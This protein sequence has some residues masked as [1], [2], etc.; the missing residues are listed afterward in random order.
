MPYTKEQQKEYMKKWRENNKK[1]IKEYKV[2]NKNRDNLKNKELRCKNKEKINEYN[3]QYRKDNPE[4]FKKVY[5]KQHY[6]MLV[7]C[8]IEVLY[9]N[10]LAETH[11]DFCCMPFTEQ[12]HPKYGNKYIKCL[13]HCHETNKFRN[14]LCNSCNSKRK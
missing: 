12:N 4:I 7:D 2:K 13:D 10:Y 6:K 11:C 9:K 14:F 5:F 3:K 1:K 8:D